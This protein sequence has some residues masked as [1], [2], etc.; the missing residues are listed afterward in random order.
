MRIQYFGDTDTLY[1]ILNENPI[2][3]TRELD[4]NLLIDVD[5]KG[6]VISLTIEHAAERIDVAKFSYEQ[7]GAP[8]LGQ[9]KALTLKD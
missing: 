5:E 9:Q 8:H 2:S 3:E 6:N 4:E 1:L 7:V